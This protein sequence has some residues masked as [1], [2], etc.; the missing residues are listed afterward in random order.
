MS[1]Y[2]DFIKKCGVKKIVFQL[3]K[4]RKVG[5]HYTFKFGKYKGAKLIEI[6]ATDRDYI[7]KL[8]EN[9]DIEFTKKDEKFIKGV[10]Y[11]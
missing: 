7:K 3:P 9:G 4:C 2:N 5:L 6:L 10:L 8:F 11:A 1:L